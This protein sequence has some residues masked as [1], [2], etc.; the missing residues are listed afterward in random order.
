MPED[1]NRLRRVPRPPRES[2]A[3]KSGLTGVI[4]I[5]SVLFCVAI[6]WLTIARE[7]VKW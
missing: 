1:L 7:G 2:P 5:A 4:A 6:V 3:V